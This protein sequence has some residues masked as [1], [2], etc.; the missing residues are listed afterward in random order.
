MRLIELRLKNLNSLKGEW[1]ID[2]AD[3]AFINE[4]IFAIT[5][6][7]GAGKTTIL[8]AICLAL[9][10]ETPRINN[11]SKSSNEVM[12][13]QTADCFAEVVIDLNGTQYRCRWGQR[14]AYGKADGNLQ[15]ATHEIALV[16]PK[17]NHH[18]NADSKDDKLKGD[19]ILESKLSRTKEKIVE[20]TRMDFQQFTRS[21]LLAQGSFS[22]FLKAKADERADILE[23]ITGT[24]IY[25]TISTHVFEKK[26]AEE[27]ILNKLQ[28]GLDGL[29]LLDADEEALINEKLTSHQTAQ[30]K[31]QQQYQRL[32]AQV[33]WFDTVAELKKNVDNHQNEV[34]VAKQAQADFAPDAKRLNA[35]NKALEIDSQYSQ[36]AHNRDNLKRL[37]ND[38]Q[39]LNHQLP[40]QEE[41]LA[42]AVNT[43]KAADAD[44][45]NA[46]DKLQITLPKIAHARK[47]D[48]AI[49]QQMQAL[50]DQQQRKQRLATN[51]QGL[52]Q[53]IE[54]HTVQ[55]KQDKAQL[56]TIE[57]YLIDAAAL[58]DI[59][60]D[61]ANF[62]SHGSRLKALLQDNAALANEKTAHHEQS[63]QYQT[64]LDQ[65]QQQQDVTN[66]LIA[67]AREALAALQK[68][69]AALTQTQSLAAIRDEQEQ[70]EHT[71]SQIEQVGFKAQHI[72]ALA[73]QINQINTALPTVNDA[74]TKLAASITDNETLMAGA[75]DRRQDKQKLL[76]S[77]QQVASLERYITQLK[78]GDP[79][80]LCGAREHPYSAHH[81]VL[82]KEPAEVAQTQQQISELDTT[83]NTL[84]QTLSKQRIEYATTQNQIKQLHEQKIPL[85]EQMKRLGADSNN[86]IQPLLAKTYSNAVTASMTQL[87]QIDAYMNLLT[88]RADDSTDS[89][90][91][92]ERLIKDSLLLLDTIKDQLSERKLSLK[93]TLTQH[94]ALSDELAKT[95]KTIE[96][97]EKQQY[98]LATDIYE[99][100]SNSQISALALDAIDKKISTNFA[101]LTQLKDAILAILNKYLAG[102][103]ELDAATKPAALQPLL[104]SIDQQIV[105][106]KADY[107]VYLDTLRQQR[108]SLVQLKQQFTAYKNAQQNLITA[109]GS[110]TVQIETKQAQLDKEETELDDLLQVITAKSE[111]LAQLTAERRDIFADNIF[112]GNV[113]NTGNDN[114]NININPDAEEARL[115]TVLEQAHSEKAA[116][117]RQLD[118][119]ELTLKQLQRQQQLL[120]EQ[121]TTASTALTTQEDVFKTALASSDFSDEAEFMRARLPAAERHHLTEQ[122]QQINDTLKQAQSLLTQTLQALA[123]KKA[124]P[125]TN[126]DRETLVEQQQLAQNELQRLIEAIGAMS[127]QLKDNE[128]KK[129]NQQAQ[130]Q[131]IAQQKDTLQVW[132][133]L[134]EL[135]GSSSGKKYRTFAQGLTFDIMVTHANAQ[136]HKM[137]DRYLLARDDNN[138]LEL[139]VIDNYQGGERR[140]T[141]NLSGG[142]GFIISLALALGLSQM[143]SHNIRVDSLFLDEGFGT[144]DDES[145]DI[146][147]DTLTS[148]QQEGK[149][150]G[151]ISHV[152]ALKERILTQIQVTKLSG[153]F[154]KITG[155]GCYH[156]AS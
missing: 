14:R 104:A 109:I 136:L 36:L 49:A 95:S 42:H 41:R 110:V 54:N 7:T 70:I 118:S 127:Q 124:N 107:E 18:N 91:I 151:V 56:A 114:S 16:T 140:S 100:K 38:Q 37:Q 65:C 90:L 105:L 5:G 24:D 50:D 125:L 64:N 120:T 93:D 143:A 81:P 76:D 113:P 57:K 122:Q 144:L 3:S 131:A 62:D 71:H 55:F 17:T 80:P 147:L 63:S 130:R 77:W 154:S 79:C 152:Q 68:Q 53:E 82:N 133:Q 123:E 126:E 112:S 115:R 73:S 66:A 142:E 139:N 75:K 35:A 150:I 117:Q 99:I 12:T 132:R 153:G 1:H 48:A 129:G 121:L 23:K 101:E 134:N 27:E 8:D 74:L 141:K 59:D 89:A 96:T 25:A 45:Q 2:F 135:I 83:I 87:G 128:E 84:E 85:Y 145:L 88:K 78:E 155:Q 148:L 106:N 103:Y 26:R 22:A 108:S 51:T 111:M 30:T 34:T 86:L 156:I 98:Q 102:K 10:G 67:K 21:I 29:T 146:A 28:F 11:I 94:E 92:K 4:G 9:Y 15:D 72:E 149:L 137:S 52:R 138:P 47:L 13:R 33:N 116:A 32:Q 19:E 46:Y 119:A 39:A 69:Q 97:F 60:T 20:L 40:Q 31:Q 44:T 58:H 61:A 6:Q 43:L